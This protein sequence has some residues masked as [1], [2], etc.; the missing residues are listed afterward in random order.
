MEEQIHILGFELCKLGEL[1][2]SSLFL[3]Q[4]EK[5]KD[6]VLPQLD[7]LGPGLNA[8]FHDLDHLLEIVAGIEVLEDKRV[9]RWVTGIQGKQS[10]GCAKAESSFFSFL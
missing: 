6:Q 5:S 4:L 2:G 10:P 7:I 9:G 8:G 1:S 3:A